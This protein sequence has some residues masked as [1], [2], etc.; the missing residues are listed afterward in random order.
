MAKIDFQ[1][2]YK[3]I[4]FGLSTRYNSFMENVDLLFTV[5]LIGNISILPGYGDYRNARQTGDI[6]FDSR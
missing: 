3:K 6:V 1:L 4:A 2:D 5:P